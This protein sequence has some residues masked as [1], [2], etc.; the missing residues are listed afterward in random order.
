MSNDPH[1]LRLNYDTTIAK[2]YST[3]F[4]VNK[5]ISI[6]EETSDGTS[7]LVSGS[8]DQAVPGLSTAY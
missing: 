1:Y 5:A 3:E 2:S 7:H 6:I 4:L 8:R